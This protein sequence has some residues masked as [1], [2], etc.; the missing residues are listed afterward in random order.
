MILRI[1]KFLRSSHGEISHKAVS[2]YLKGYLGKSASSYNNE[3]K[4][5]RRF[6]GFLGRPELIAPFKM[7]PPD[8]ALREL[9]T[10][11]EVRRGFEAQA[12][13]RD[14][15]LY[16]LFASSGLR[17]SEVLTLERGQVDLESRAV[18]VN[19][20]TR[21][22]RAGLA[23]FNPEAE[24]YLRDYLAMR[25]DDKSRLFPIGVRTFNKIWR[26]ASEAAGVKI[27]PQ[28][29]RAWN[30]SELG[31]RGVP[32]RY[33][34]ILQGRAPRSVIARHYTGVEFKRLKRIYDG[35]GLRIL[36]DG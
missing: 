23:F 32:D 5:L 7:A 25:K 22:K 17:R 10:L 14:R 9:P 21:T 4:A 24:R 11:E 33:V 8:Y 36:G 12:S 16:L 3:I 27:S 15:A 29:L 13:L 19:H 2:D 34:D 26:R 28:I 20:N 6:L 35:A 18:R 1:K 31:E 30:A